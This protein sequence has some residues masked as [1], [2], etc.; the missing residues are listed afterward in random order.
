MMNEKELSKQIK[1]QI[2]QIMAFY[3]DKPE[4]LM[5]KLECLVFEWFIKG[6]NID[7]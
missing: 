3:G 5:Y 2:A 1:H 7:K 6:Q 4:E